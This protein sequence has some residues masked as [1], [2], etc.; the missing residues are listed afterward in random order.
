MS[1]YAQPAPVRQF[2]LHIPCRGFGLQ[3]QRM[4]TEIQQFSPAGIERVVKLRRVLREL[5]RR[6]ESRRAHTGACM[7]VPQTL[8]VRCSRLEKKREKTCGSCVSILL[9]ATRS[10]YK[11]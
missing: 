4:S 9:T 5:I 2:L 11:R 10:K 1:Q 7:T 6:V 3:A 8:H